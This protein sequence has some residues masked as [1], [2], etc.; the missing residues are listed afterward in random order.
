ML[1]ETILFLALLPIVFAADSAV[2][3]NSEGLD[4]QH[5]QV[6]LA[7]D[8]LNKHIEGNVRIDFSMTTASDDVIFNCGQL[9]VTAVKGRTVKGFKQQGEELLISLSNVRNRDHH[10]RIYYEGF[11]S[12]GV[13]FSADP[14][15]VYTVFATPEWMVCHTSPSDRATI[16]L[17][18]TFPDTLFCI[19]NGELVTQTKK[20]EHQVKQTWSLQQPSPAFTYGFA[21]GAF[22]ECKEHHQRISLNYYAVNHKAAEL[23]KIF[24]NTSDMLTF[25]E[26]KSGLP[27]FQTSYSQVLMG[28]HY[29]EMSGFAVLKNIYGDLV[30]KDSTET[31]LISHELAHQ[32]WGIQMT[33]QNW[34]HF[35]LNEGFATYMSAAYNEHRF[36]KEKYI[37]DITSYRAVYEKIKSKGQDKPLVFK[38]WSSPSQDDRNLVYFKGA[39]VIHLLRE[40]LGD[41]LFWKA[42]KAYSTSYDGQSVTTE[43]FQE[44]IEKSSG[45]DLDVFFK[46]WIY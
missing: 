23:K 8:L 37:A 6:D 17:D 28:N 12:K 34:N 31:N 32:W 4:V 2:A 7:I 16:N 36:G 22:N 19:A 45:K 30:L 27:Y 43:K 38:D 25:F 44:A 15:Q 20:A 29:Q 35:W 24:S 40:H 26:E 13:F 1:K 11:P 14:L 39:Y 46:E 3:Q 5:Y 33:C 42:I 9:K 18:L 41:E 21:L 10:I